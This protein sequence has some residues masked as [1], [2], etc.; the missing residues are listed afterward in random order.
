MHSHN[1]IT[2]PIKRKWRDSKKP[3]MICV[4]LDSMC[5]TSTLYNFSHCPCQKSKL[6]RNEFYDGGAEIVQCRDYENRKFVSP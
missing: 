1:E 2:N 4:I 6:Q 5:I 3:T